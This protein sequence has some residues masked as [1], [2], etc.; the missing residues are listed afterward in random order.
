MVLHVSNS[1]KNTIGTYLQAPSIFSMKLCFDVLLPH[2]L[3]LLELL[4]VSDGEV[5]SRVSKNN[6]LLGVPRA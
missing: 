2:V 6:K 4:L 3:L 1:V 5:L